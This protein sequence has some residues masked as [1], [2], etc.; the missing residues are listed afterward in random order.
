MYAKIIEKKNLSQNLGDE[1]NFVDNKGSVQ[2][3]RFMILEVLFSAGAL[4]F[5]YMLA[6]N[7][8]PHQMKSFFIN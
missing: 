6:L 3:S 2:D 1:T 8:V 7:E 4:A 5:T